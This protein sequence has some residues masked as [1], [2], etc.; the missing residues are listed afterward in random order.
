MLRLIIDGPGWTDATTFYTYDNKLVGIT[1]LQHDNIEI[2]NQSLEDALDALKDLEWWDEDSGTHCYVEGD[3]PEEFTDNLDSE[4]STE[5][6]TIEDYLY[7][8][9]YNEEEPDE[10]DYGSFEEFAEDNYLRYECRAKEVWMDPEDAGKLSI[11]SSYGNENCDIMWV[12]QG[13]CN[14]S[15]FEDLMQA[16]GEFYKEETNGKTYTA[17]MKCRSYPGAGNFIKRVVSFDNGQ[18][19]IEDS[20]EEVICE[21]DVELKIQPHYD[22]DLNFVIDCRD[23]DIQG[24]GKTIKEAV[25]DFE[26]ELDSLNKYVDVDPGYEITRNEVTLDDCGI[27]KDLDIG[28]YID[29]LTPERQQEIIDNE[30]ILTTGHY[31][32]FEKLKD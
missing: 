21:G 26:S 11:N 1:D 2:T 14:L 9:G 19:T 7:D 29:T 8:L 27:D 15:D 23:E 10:D 13:D 4:N 12:C 18:Y 5:Y 24:W 30:E 16:F 32:T 31:Q 6:D 3:T 28:E 25:E 17:V 22:D 20:P